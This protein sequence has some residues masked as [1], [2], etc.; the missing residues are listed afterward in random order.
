MRWLSGVGERRLELAGLE[1]R[2][3]D[4]CCG[5]FQLLLVL[6]GFGVFLADP[7]VALALEQ[8]DQFGAAVLDDPAA[9]EDVDEL[10]L[11]VGEDPLVVGDDQD[12]GAV[13]RR[14]AIDPLGDDAHGVDIE[15]AIGLVEDGER[16]AEHGHLEDLGPLLLAA[17][18]PLVQVPPG[19][20]L[21][22]PQLIHLLA[23]LLAEVAHRDQVFAFLAA[24]VADVGHRV[25][26][27]VGHRDPG[28]RRRVL[29]RQEDPGLG[30]L[31]GLHGQ[32]VTGRRA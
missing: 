31:V 19:E 17:G 29:E 25:A 9:E 30:P 23:Q 13:P 2:G 22:D 1:R 26:Q 28:D 6:G 5:G 10:G 12:A 32:H 20:F 21:V 7:V 24:R 16:R 4:P 15:A 11:D 18:E 14:D 27:E 8:L 3:L